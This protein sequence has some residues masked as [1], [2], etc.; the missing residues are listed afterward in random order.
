MT[1]KLRN[2]P[3]KD[4]NYLGKKSLDIA[5]SKKKIGKNIIKIINRFK[6]INRRFL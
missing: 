3:K 6:Y 5:K 2:H 1:K 4:A